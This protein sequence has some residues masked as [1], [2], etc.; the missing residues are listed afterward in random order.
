MV[1]QVTMLINY[2]GKLKT[3]KMKTNDIIKYGLY[4]MGAYG[5]YIL[6]KAR[7]N[8]KKEIQDALNRWMDKLCN[9]TTTPMDMATL[10]ARDGVLLGTVAERIHQGTVDISDY[11][12]GFL[13]MQPCGEFDEIIIQDYGMGAVADGLYTFTLTNEEGEVEEVKA[14]FTYVFKEEDGMWKITTHHS[15][16]DPGYQIE[17]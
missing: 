15:S 13:T 4:G 5:I 16:T 2:Y 8:N 3:K 11:F 17:E 14:R 12:E 9:P 1:H 7:K 10:Y 6:F